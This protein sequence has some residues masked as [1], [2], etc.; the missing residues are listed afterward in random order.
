[1]TEKYRADID[2]LRAIAVVAV[3]LFHAFPGAFP[4]GFVGV[5]IFFVISGFLISGILISEFQLGTY[6]L[7]NFYIRRIRRIFPALVTVLLFSFLAGWFILLPAEFAQLGKHIV[8]AASFCVNLVLWNESGYFDNAA[9]TK[10][11]LHLWSLGVEEQFYIIWPI[12]L[13]LTFRR[14]RSV[15]TMTAIIFAA[16]FI[17][18]IAQSVSNSTADFYSPLT[19]FWELLAGA[20]IA[21]V[22][23]KPRTTMSSWMEGLQQSK[24]FA[25]LLSLT[26]LALIG[27]S[28]V[29]VRE[30]GFPGWQAL[31]PVFGTVFIIAAGSKA[32]PNRSLL[33]LRP[34]IYVGLV[35]YPLYLWHWPLLSFARIYTQAIPGPLLAA[36]LLG[37][38]FLLASATYHWIERP[39]RQ[40]YFARNAYMWLIAAMAGLGLAGLATMYF[41]GFSDRAVAKNNMDLEAKFDGGLPSSAIRCPN[42]TS[43][44]LIFFNCVV[45]GREPPRFALLGD[46]KAGALYEGILRT[47]EPGGRWLFLG[48]GD[49]GPLVPVLTDDPFY[50][51]VPQDAVQSAIDQIK[52]NSSVDTVV[53]ATATRALFRLKNDRDI[54]DLPE[55]P[56][57]NNALDGLDRAVGALLTDS[58]RRI[59]LLIDNPTLPPPEDCISRVTGVP[60]L[61]KLLGRTRNEACAI[62]VARQLE[63]SAQY[64]RLLETIA[65]RHPGRVELFD[66]IPVLCDSEAGLCSMSRNG[67]PL[68]GYTDHI[69]D[70]AGT[71]LGTEINSFLED[72]RVPPTSS[73]SSGN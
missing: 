62:P 48:S 69:S 46:S 70:Y 51:S 10:P 58:D 21:I 61:N 27:S 66:T 39:F 5:D 44:E 38:S 36:V 60:L 2:G 7:K 24:P 25:A 59:I 8:A 65:E 37:I 45:D 53:I 63:L 55:S 13:W 3:L 72:R 56:N 30:E 47:S 50:A 34:M 67:R 57:F 15:A 14:N 49:S 28:L 26:G 68:Y 17:L 32:L 40:K 33:S 42:L 11:L 54:E 19:R 29:F 9:E 43:E 18:N 4:G 1:M 22:S 23:A 52:A 6:S 12:L 31:F 20:V 73:S 35:S 71:I 41:Q 16:S 64:R